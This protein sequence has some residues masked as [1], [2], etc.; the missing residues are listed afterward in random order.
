[1]QNKLRLPEDKIIIT[2]PGR[3]TE[4]KGQEYFLNVLK[5]IKSK[6]YLCLMVGDIKK[7]YKYIEKIKSLIYKYNL[8]EYIKIHDNIDDMPALYALSNIVVS[9]S[10]RPESFGRVSIEA[11]AMGKLFVGTTMG[12]ICETVIDSKTGFLAPENN[13]RE[14]AK[15]LDKVINLSEEEKLKISEQSRQNVV[16]NFS[17]DTM[18]DRMLSLYNRIEEYGNFGHWD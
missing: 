17:F 4:Q 11:Q 10:I 3:F 1:M 8:Q 16:E 12:A 13:A 9:P 14:F 5:Y 2:L 18:Y 7:N 6:N 15:I